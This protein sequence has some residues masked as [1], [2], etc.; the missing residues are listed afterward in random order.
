MSEIYKNE[1]VTRRSVSEPG[2]YICV[3]SCGCRMRTLTATADPFKGT[4]KV[5]CAQHAHHKLPQDLWKACIPCLPGG[6]VWA[7]CPV[8]FGGE[9]YEK[10]D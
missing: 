10:E 6:T 5:R 9:K 1:N 4:F 7:G 8:D 3:M 2:Y